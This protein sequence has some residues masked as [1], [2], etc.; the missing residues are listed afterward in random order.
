MKTPTITLGYKVILTE[1][2]LSKK[3]AFNPLIYKDL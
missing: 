1:N 3:Y 2:I